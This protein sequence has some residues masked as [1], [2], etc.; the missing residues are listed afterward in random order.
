M[1]TRTS[2]RTIAGR[3]RRDTACANGDQCTKGAARARAR[4]D[5][6][7]TRAT[8]RLPPVRAPSCTQSRGTAPGDHG[9]EERAARKRAW[10]PRDLGC[11]TGAKHLRDQGTRDAARARTR[12][13]VRITRATGRL[14]LVR[15]AGRTHS[16]GTAPGDH[17]R[18]RGAQSAIVRSCAC[19]SARRPHASVHQ[20][21]GAS[22]RARG[23]SNHA[24]YRATPAR[25]RSELHAEPRYG[26]WGPREGR[27]R[28]AQARMGP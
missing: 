3:L 26:T 7:I 19:A 20:G 27:T 28:S 25:S 17:G 23:R 14:P 8:G 4:A 6:R 2:D 1:H 21:R 15:A 10:D 12:A 9:K 5:I 24:G 18:A 16:R 13:R 11:A 22:S